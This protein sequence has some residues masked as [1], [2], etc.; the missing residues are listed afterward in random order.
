MDADDPLSSVVVFSRDRLGAGRAVRIMKLY[1]HY[2]QKP[3]HPIGNRIT[4]LSPDNRTTQWFRNRVEH[5]ARGLGRV[6]RRL[7]R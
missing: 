6:L 3:R 7:L 2:K 4:F 5:G 1:S